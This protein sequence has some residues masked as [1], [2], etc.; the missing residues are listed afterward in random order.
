MKIEI[1][2]A[3]EP[4]PGISP[5]TSHLE[6][7]LQSNKS[8]PVDI[9]IRTPYDP[10]DASIWLSEKTGITAIILPYTIGGND[11]SDNLFAL[12]DSSIILLK[13]ALYDK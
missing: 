4:K 10:K 7:L 1:D 6:F 8:N 12:F 13:K 11:Q 3:I 2:A 9:I 5:S